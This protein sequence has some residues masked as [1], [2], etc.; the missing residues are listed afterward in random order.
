MY[1]SGMECASLILDLR[2]KLVDVFASHLSDLHEP[3]T[4]SSSLGRSLQ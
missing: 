1:R 4:L 2:F 3:Y